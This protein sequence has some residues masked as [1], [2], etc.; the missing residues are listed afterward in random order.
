MLTQDKSTLTIRQDEARLGGM[1]TNATTTTCPACTSS[2]EWRRLPHRILA[3]GSI[4]IGGIDPVEL[5]EAPLYRPIE[6]AHKLGR[7]YVR[8]SE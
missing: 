4:A 7:L 2:L 1:N 5:C 3:D 6:S 8:P